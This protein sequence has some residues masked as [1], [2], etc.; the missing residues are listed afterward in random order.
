MYRQRNEGR[1]DI[2]ISLRSFLYTLFLNCEE[3]LPKISKIFLIWFCRFRIICVQNL[4]SL[5][6]I[7][8]IKFRLPDF[9]MQRISHK[10]V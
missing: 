10:N 4:K 3:I 7:R 5:S 9:F 1:V 6:P 2:A 8:F